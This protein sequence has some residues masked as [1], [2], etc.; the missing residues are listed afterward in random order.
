MATA[1]GILRGRAD[2]DATA[3]PFGDDA[4][5]YRDLAE[6]AGRRAALFGELRDDGRPPHIGVLL[7]SIPDYLFWLAAA[8]MRAVSSSASTPPTG[9]SSSACWSG[10][11]TA[12]C[13]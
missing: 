1:A 8:A 4:W 10:T 9:A 11:P 13:S 5:T 2:S 7:E 3:L 6:E 12:S